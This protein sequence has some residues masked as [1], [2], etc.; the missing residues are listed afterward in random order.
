MTDHGGIPTAIN[1]YNLKGTSQPTILAYQPKQ[2]PNTETTTSDQGSDGAP[3]SAPHSDP[4]TLTLRTSPSHKEP[5]PSDSTPGSVSL[6]NSLCRGN[7]PAERSDP[8][9]GP[10]NP[11]LSHHDRN[12]WARQAAMIILAGCGKLTL[13]T[14]GDF[15]LD[16][17]S[18]HNS[19]S[20]GASPPAIPVPAPQGSRLGIRGEEV[21]LEDQPVGEEVG[22]KPRLVWLLGVVRRRG[23]DIR[24]KCERRRG[25][26]KGIIALESMVADAPSWFADVDGTGNRDKGKGVSRAPRSSLA[27]CKTLR[28]SQEGRDS[29]E[30]G[31]Q[32]GPEGSATAAWMLGVNEEGSEPETNTVHLPLSSTENGLGSEETSQGSSTGKGRTRLRLPILRIRKRTDASEEPTKTSHRQQDVRAITKIFG[33]LRNSAK[34]RASEDEHGKANQ[35]SMTVR[36]EDTDR[37]VLVIA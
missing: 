27:N 8:A 23:K 36:A 26:A 18:A 3:A 9:S 10:L 5:S 29:R 1:S 13:S 34:K 35:G 30:G 25:D 7:N 28:D 19:A 2:R 17:D 6:C 37:S 16:S 14:A 31:S 32:P 20:G 24:G 33:R 12:Q 21:W 11:A 22:R 4:N 15:G